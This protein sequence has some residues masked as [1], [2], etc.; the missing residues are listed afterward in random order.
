MAENVTIDSLK[1]GN[2]NIA[3]DVVGVIASIAA[4]E[5][6]GISALS[7]T[8]SDDVMEMIGKKNMN[9]GV[10]VT[11]NDNVA[12]VDLTVVVDY[13]TKIHEV[14]VQVQENVKTAIESMTGISVSGVNVSVEGIHLKK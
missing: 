7:G 5:I 14:S 10:H 3:D 11:L 4:A 9:K 1:H 6:E 8:L 2:V 12:V 13:G